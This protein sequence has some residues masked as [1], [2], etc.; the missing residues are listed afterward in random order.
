M[1]MIQAMI[2]MKGIVIPGEVRGKLGFLPTFGLQVNSWN[3]F[4]YLPS[5]YDSKLLSFLVLFVL[6]I[7]ALKLPNTQE[8]AEKIDFNPFWAFI[9][10]LLATYYLLS[11][12]RV[13]EFLYFQF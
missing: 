3:K 12:N 2:G 8:I 9:L 5:F 7:G 1:E 10:G 6:M 13:S 11:L 4:T